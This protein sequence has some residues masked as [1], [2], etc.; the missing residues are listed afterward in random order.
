MIGWK[1]QEDKSEQVWI[2][3]RFFASIIVFVLMKFTVAKNDRISN[4]Q[5]WLIQQYFVFGLW[6][7]RCKYLRYRW[8]KSDIFIFINHWNIEFQDVTNSW[9]QTLS[10]HLLRLLLLQTK[11]IACS[12]NSNALCKQWWKCDHISIKQQYYSTHYGLY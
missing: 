11:T 5:L 8:S 12:R 7:N 2:A 9:T 10:T 6:N 1:P 4:I 3:F